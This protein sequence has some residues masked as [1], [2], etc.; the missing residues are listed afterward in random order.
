MK[1]NLL[2]RKNI[3]VAIL[4]C[5]SILAFRFDAK[6]SLMIGYLFT[7]V[8]V[9]FV[10]FF[11]NRKAGAALAIPI[12][13]LGMLLRKYFPMV[14]HLKPEKMKIYLS[15]LSKYHQF[16]KDYFILLLVIAIIIGYFGGF[17]GEYLNKNNQRKLTVSNLT[18]IAMFVAISVAINT[19]RI[20]DISFG[21]FPIIVSG[22]LLGPIY[23]FVVGAISDVV[24]F[25]VRPSANAFN[26]LF[27][28]TSALTGLIPVL[29]TKLLKDEYP[30]YTFVKV[31]I[32]IFIGQMLTSV[33]MV[34][35]FR[36]LI[37][38]KS[39]FWFLATK[40]FIKQAFSIPFYAFYTVSLVDRLSKVINF[41]KVKKS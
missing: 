7:L 24:G 5:I 38:G 9:M 4:V 1:N 19:V 3:F 13:T 21:G 28:L 25:I 40:A 12:L 39:T 26:P 30:K 34:P 8:G 16:L 22:Y 23:G 2:N 37:Y 18:H 41:K 35:I 32:G 17:V 33:I 20:G 31:L 11:T 27:I 10:G 29:V 14:V 15:E 6:P 36:V